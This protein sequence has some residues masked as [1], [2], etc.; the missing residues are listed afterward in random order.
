[1]SK[2]TLRPIRDSQLG[3][4]STNLEAIGLLWWYL[5]SWPAASSVRC[6]ALRAVCWRARRAVLLEDESGEQPAIA[7][8]ER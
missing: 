3:L 7:L 5:D 2:L 1:M 6:A 4:Y 8:K